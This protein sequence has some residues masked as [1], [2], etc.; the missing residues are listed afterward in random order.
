MLLMNIGLGLITSILNSF[1]NS[2]QVY[3]MVL[4]EVSDSTSFVYLF[5]CLFVY[6]LLGSHTAIRMS[7][8]WQRNVI[9][10][11]WCVVVGVWGG[12]VCVCVCVV[13]GGGTRNVLF[14]FIFH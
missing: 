8:Y 9:G 12:W 10:R 6:V 3:I 2:S 1:R 11:W 13:G 7:I 4:D 5:I 14:L